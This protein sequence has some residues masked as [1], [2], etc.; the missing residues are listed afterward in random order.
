FER[1]LA[2][3]FDE[4]FGRLAN[5]SQVIGQTHLVLDRQ[6]IIIAAF[7]DFLGHI[8][9]EELIAL[10]AGPGAVFEDEA[11][12]EAGARYQ[13][14]AALKRFFGLAAETDDEIAADRDI[15]DSLAATG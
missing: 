6:Q 7:L 9:C 4:D 1:R 3:P 14:A 2:R 11:V 13:I 10:G 5:M 8:I 15:G 12:L